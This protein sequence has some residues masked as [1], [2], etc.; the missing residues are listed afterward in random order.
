MRQGGMKWYPVKLAQNNPD[1]THWTYRRFVEPGQEEFSCFQTDEPE[2]LENL[3]D[4]YYDR[5]AR[6][7]DGRPDLQKRFVKGEYGFTQS[8]NA[9]T[10]QWSDRIHL[11]NELKALDSYPLTLCWDWGLNPTCIITQVTPLGHW[12][13]LES[14][15]GDGIG[16]YQLINEVI[17]PRL[18]SRYP[19]LEIQHT[20]DPMGKQREQSDSEQSALRLMQKELGGRWKPGPV[21]VESRLEPLRGVL[22]RQR[23][24]IG[25]V[26]VDRRYAKAVWHA[27]RGGWAYPISRSG[28]VGERPLKNIHSHP[29]DAVSYGSAFLFPLGERRSSRKRRNRSISHSGYGIIDRHFGKPGVVVPPEAKEL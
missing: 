1:E 20:G 3:P 5:L 19:D 10:P 6:A 16:A 15:V 7:Y 28:V 21:R 11:A 4:D 8:G 9:I 24:G 2:N 25:I 26:Q 27:L 12:N 23:D 17:K 22:S 29:G 18:T 14:H 13:I